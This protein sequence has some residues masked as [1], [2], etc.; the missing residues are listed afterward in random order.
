MMLALGLSFIAFEMTRN[1]PSIHSFL[2]AFI[3]M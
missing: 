2:R 1:I 3:M